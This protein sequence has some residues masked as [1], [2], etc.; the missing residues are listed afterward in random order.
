MI[1][2]ALASYNGARFIA[3]QLESILC[4]L[5]AND[6]V[7]V[8]DDASSDDTVSVVQSL[9]DARVRVLSHQERVGYIKNF[10]RCIG[11]VRGTHVFLADQDDVWLPDKVSTA[12]DMLE[13]APCV[14][15]DAVVVGE[16]LQVLFP[17]Y[18]RQ[19]KADASGALS[20]L[21]RPSIIGATL[22]CRRE[23]LMSYLPFPQGVPHDYWLAMNAALRGELAII[24]RP[25]IL[26]RRHASA[27]SAT[28]LDRKRPLSRILAERTRLIAALALRGLIRR[29]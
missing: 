1:S 2:V 7:V 23:F 3:A 22:A 10:E 9:S 28:A 29:S 12:V 26:Y 21:L 18:F 25:L 15:S 4:Q 14:A 5:G 24:N 20:L 19:R 11:A 13:I 27:V 16:N 6:E 8:S 17:S